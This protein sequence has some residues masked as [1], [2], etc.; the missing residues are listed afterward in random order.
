VC[1]CVCVF[2][3]VCVC[4]CVCVQCAASAHDQSAG[5]RNKRI[6]RTKHMNEDANARREGGRH[7]AVGSGKIK[8]MLSRD[9]TQQRTHS[10]CLLVVLAAAPSCSPVCVR[11]CWTCERKGSERIS[12]HT[13]SCFFCMCIMCTRS[14]RKVHMVA[15]VLSFLFRRSGVEEVARPKE[16]E[17][18]NRGSLLTT[19]ATASTASSRRK[20]T[21]R[22]VAS[23]CNGCGNASE[24]VKKR[25]HKLLAHHLV[26][27]VLHPCCD[28]SFVECGCGF[29]SVGFVR[30]S[31]H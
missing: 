5:Q 20:F 26:H 31:R 19:I 9:S 12:A 30:M 16:R 25:C 8:V 3:C 22:C 13:C 17:K 27:D 6:C 11:V 14:V 4:V 24:V 21:E 1:V 2:V 23:C 28:V 10:V 18:K 15:R 29:V 7:L